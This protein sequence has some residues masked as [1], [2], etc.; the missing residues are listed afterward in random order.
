MNTKQRIVR[1]IT[2]LILFFAFASTVSI[3]YAYWNNLTQDTNENMNIGDWG[4]P[5]SSAQ[6][7]YDFAMKADS[8]TTDRY[9][10]LNDIDFSGFNWT[11]TSTNNTVTFRGLLDGNG[12]TLSNLT[13]Y[14]NSSSY[15]YLGI[16]P[17]M[18][19]G[20]VYNLTLDNVNL[21]LGSTALG[22]SSLRSGLITGNII[23][24]TNTISDITILNSGVR[25]TSTTGTGGLVGSV[26]GSTTIVNI[27]NIKATSLKVF[28]KS[29]NAGGLVGNVSTS[30]AQIHVSDI[31]LEGEVFAYGSSS[32]TGGI[33]GQVASGAM[34]TIDRIV[35]DVTSRNTL[36]TNSTY[37]NR[38]SQRYLGGFVGYSLS[39]SA[40]ILISDAF[41]TGSLFTQSS[42]RASSVGTATG[43]FSATSTR[44]TL[45]RTFYSQVIFSSSSGTIVYTPSSTPS[46]QMATLVNAASMP[47]STW[48]N[49]FA[50]AGNFSSELWGQDVATGRL[51]LIR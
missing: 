15:S 12:K 21:S 16:F 29:S 34:V 6:E 26:T 7:F 4:I 2:I 17:R 19:G 18:S 46:G 10:L 37:Y 45:L 32:Y 48:W 35:L 36:E 51:Y 20:S 28:S 11:Y 5:I 1:I 22:G 49:G 27:D 41:F 50:T 31:D 40:N 14:I 24:S 38:Y 44:P 39:A 43:R 30:G 25:G 8:V 13:L 23:G 42:T 33:I 47:S 9:F 3:G